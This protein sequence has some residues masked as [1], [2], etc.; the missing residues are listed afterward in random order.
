MKRFVVGISDRYEREEPFTRSMELMKREPHIDFRVLHFPDELTPSES[1]DYD[2]LILTGR[3]KVTARTLEGEVR[4]KAIA[5]FGVGYD[6]IDIRACTEKGVAVCITPEG[7]TK[8]V[9]VAMLTLLLSLTSRIFTKDRLVRSGRWEERQRH[10]GVGLT[11]RT[12]GAV[13]LGRIASEFF[14]LARP[15]GMKHIAYDPFLPEQNVTNAGIRSVELDTLLKEADFISINCPL[16]DATTRLIGE[17]ELELMKR[18]AFLINT[19][20][21]KIVD[22]RAL[23]EALKKGRILGAALDVFEDE[24]LDPNDPLIELDNVILTPHSIAWTDELFEGNISGAIRRVLQVANG[25]RPSDI[26]NPEAWD[27]R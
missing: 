25:E 1:R 22:Q 18:G 6:N 14:R 20:R 3:P 9:A 8:P 17:R 2:A 24:P 15:L 4:L 19:A 13:G 27:R 5:R 11:G 7:V 23:T 12:F 26:V 10:N 16:T 21:G